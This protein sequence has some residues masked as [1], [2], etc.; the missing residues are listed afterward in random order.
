MRFKFYL[1]VLLFILFVLVPS[2]GAQ[3]TRIIRINSSGFDPSEVTIKIGED[4]EFQNLDQV[5]RWP[6]SNIHPT[7][8]IYPEF[9][10]RNPIKPNDSWQFK[11]ERAGTFKFH[12]HLIP[13]L[14]GTIKVEGEEKK[15]S[16][17]NSINTDYLKSQGYRIY[18]FLFPQKLAVELEKL[19]AHKVSV[20]KNLLK[21][22][23]IIV[24]GKKYMDELVVDTDGGSKVDCHQE[25]HL[26]GRIAYE[27]F[28]GLTFKDINYG[29]H[30][31]YL[32]G[33]MEAFISEN[34]GDN[35][36]KKVEKL[37][38]GFKTEFSIFE[39]LHGIGHGFMAY[40]DY[41]IPEGLDLCKQ[42]IDTFSKRSCFGGIFMENILVAEGKGAS[43]GHLTSWV[44]QDPHF[45]CKAVDQDELI[46]FECYQM[47][48]SRML[49]LF[50]Y[51]F[52]PI[53]R[54]CLAAPDNMVSVCFKSMGR[55][56]AG[57]TLRDPDKISKLCQ[58]SPKK[59]FRN[60]LSGALNVIVDFWGENV[61]N[62]PHQLCNL[63]NQDDL[64]YCYNLLGE[65]LKDIFGSDKPKIKTICEASDKLYVN[66]C[67]EGSS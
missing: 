56:I 1:L 32:H 12:D 8:G 46:Q 27:I 41:D 7:H 37:C 66:N 49:H 60:C 15:D 6:A 48:T 13:N 2:A 28:G 16:L 62:Q 9:D 45:P 35:L 24:G 21:K 67:L 38:K 51:D 33:A 36:P 50:N 23:L 5:D 39:C 61:E 18:F 44:N 55:D 63:Q 17:L 42:L 11:F 57:Q 47:Q 43:P 31:G 30:S 4:V 53:T 64:G 52:L 25:A 59:Y 26:I 20:D 22:W 14:T 10:P 29:C 54:E 3:A 19:N 34:G 58:D 40:L 65:R